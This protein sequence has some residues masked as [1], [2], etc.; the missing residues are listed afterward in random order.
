[1]T[2]TLFAPQLQPVW[3]LLIAIL[4]ERLWAWPDRYHPLGFVRL[5]AKQMAAKVNHNDNN[6]FQQKI[7]G[8]LAP[9]VLLLP[10]IIGATILIQ[11]AEFPLFFDGL[12][13]LVALQFKPVT[14]RVRRVSNALERNKKALARDILQYLCLR[15]TQQLSVIGISKAAIETLL[16]RYCYQYVAVMFWFLALGGVGAISYRLVYEF[17]LHWNTKLERYRHFGTP[18]ARLSQ[19]LYW[20]P[21]RIMIAGL[22]LS[23]NISGSFRALRQRKNRNTHTAILAACG[24]GLKVQLSGPVMYRGQKYRYAKLGASRLPETQDIRR[25]LN[26]LDKTLAILLV[27]S[28]L[29]AAMLY[30][31]RKLL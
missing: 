31:L 2:E 13:L 7:A 24:G 26:A 17:S 25:S 3:V 8:A 1:M 4:V 18:V 11:L 28:L 6:A 23:E 21:A 29:I 5:I 30:G 20:L 14:D 15:E 10:F 9:T 12:L 27:F 22:M 19:F 16:L